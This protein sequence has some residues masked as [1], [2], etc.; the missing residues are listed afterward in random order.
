[1]RDL[2]R[3]RPARRLRG[4]GGPVGEIDEARRHLDWG[5]SRQ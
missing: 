3:V 4:Y 5:A 2:P 1:M